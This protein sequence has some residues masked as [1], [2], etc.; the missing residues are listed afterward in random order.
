MILRNATKRLPAI[1]QLA[2]KVIPQ[3]PARPECRQGNTLGDD[4]E[5]LFR[6]SFFQQFRLCFRYHAPS[7]VIA[8]AWV[9]MWAPSGHMRAVTIPA[10][11]SARCWSVVIGP[12]IGISCFLRHGKSRSRF[13]RRLQMR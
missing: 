4:N 9:L 12:T 1:A 11:F 6:A 10:G 5:H 13:W 2:F 3:D 8:Y 7:K